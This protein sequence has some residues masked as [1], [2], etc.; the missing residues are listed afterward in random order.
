MVD[1]AAI[2][3]PTAPERVRARGFG[4]SDLMASILGIALILAT[5]GGEFRGLIQ[6]FWWLC[7]AIAAYLGPV[8]RGNWGPP[9]YLLKSMADYGSSVVWHGIQASELVVLV[10]TPVALL[11]RL[12][13]PRPSFRGLIRQPGTVA[14]LSVALGFVLV[15]NWLHRLFVGLNPGLLTPIAVGGTVALAWTVLALSGRCE[16]ERSWV[17]RLGRALGATA[18]AVGLVSALRYGI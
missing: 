8:P 2:L 13:Q 10:M 15:V 12:R 18:I 11:M 1:D 9:Q 7:R 17:D 14:G 5:G 16:I 3:T 6:Q 4:I